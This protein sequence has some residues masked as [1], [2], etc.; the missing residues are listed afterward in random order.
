MIGAADQV[1]ELFPDPTWTDVDVADAAL[2]A[3]HLHVT[4]IG[5]M[6]EHGLTEEARD[7]ARE[8]AHSLVARDVTTVEQ[9]AAL[10]R[11]LE[12]LTER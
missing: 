8:L 1:Q 12:L 5:G 6:R 7:L 4:V 3:D 9:R 10:S 11:L 2:D